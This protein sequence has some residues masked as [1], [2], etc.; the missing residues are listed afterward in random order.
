MDDLNTP[1]AIRTMQDLVSEPNEN[2]ENEP[3]E[4]NFG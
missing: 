3:Y 2:I 4:L 1:L